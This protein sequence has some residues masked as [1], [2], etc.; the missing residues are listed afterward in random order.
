MAKNDDLKLLGAWF[1]PFALRVQIALN[2]KGLDYEN[3]E[4]TLNPKSDLLLQSNP[5]HKKVPVLLHAGKP[6]CESSIIVEYIDEVWTNAPS[7][8]PT[9]AY[10]RAIARFWTA[11]V[12]EKAFVFL[13]NILMSEDDEEKKALF[14]QMEEVLDRMEEALKKY[15][16]GKAYFG[17]DTI[18]CI[19]IAFG[20][21]LRWINVIEKMNGRIVLDE[22][23]NPVLAKWAE[24]FS[25][26]PAVNGLLPETDKLIEYANVLKQKMAAM[27]LQNN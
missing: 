23:K 6:I 20:S 21:F 2:L 15:S 9:N 19:D 3:I 17:G 1:S 7:I 4:E 26:D 27:K 13:R 10:D 5:V 16:E 25:V 11:Y 24:T 14:G 22:A 18:G 8:L 12:D